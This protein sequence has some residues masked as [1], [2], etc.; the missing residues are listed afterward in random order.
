M[1]SNKDYEILEHTADIGIRLKGNSLTEIFWKA[2]HATADLLSGGIEI[3]PVI[4]REFSVEEEN[5]ET[6]LVSILEEIIYFFE[7]ELFLPSVCSVYIENDRY[8]IKLKGNI[9]S[10]EDIKNG[11]E[12]KAVTYHQLEIKEVGNE[13]QATVIFDV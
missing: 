6:A 11:T 7:K 4:E 13:Y 9:V 2:I 10:A 3:Q 8:Q 5:M 12:I 1:G